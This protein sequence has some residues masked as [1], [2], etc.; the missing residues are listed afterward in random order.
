M[1]SVVV[2]ALHL[3]V[4]AVAGEVIS[5]ATILVMRRLRVGRK[6]G[7]VG[8]GP[9]G[10][11][12]KEESGLLVGAAFLA[13]VAVVG[14]IPLTL[15][16]AVLEVL[17]LEAVAAVD[18]PMALTPVLVVLVVMACAAFIAGEVRDEIRNH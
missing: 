4:E 5:K 15:G 13:A 17:P 6:P 1:Q 8:A 3:V 18:R 12:P 11:L 16:R 14:A 7:L 2:D 10:Q 9:L